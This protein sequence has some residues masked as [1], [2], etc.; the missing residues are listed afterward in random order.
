MLKYKKY[1]AAVLVFLTL[2]AGG[3]MTRHL[4]KP[5]SIDTLS[6]LDTVQEVMQSQETESLNIEESV[7]AIEK[8]PEIITYQVK[9]GDTLESI[10]RRFGVS[11]GAIAGSSGISRDSVIKEGQE[12]RFPSIDGVLYKI[13]SGETLWDISSTYGKSVAEITA[14]N[15]MDS[16]DKLKIGQEIIIPG[17]TELKAAK[18]PSNSSPASGTKNA[19]KL[20]SRG[21]S[22][23][24]GTSSNNTSTKG[25]WPLKGT[26]TSKYG[27]RWGTTHKGI[28]IAAPTGTNVN[29]F[30]GGKVSFS[31]WQGGY[32]KLVIIDHGNGLKSYYGHNSKLIVSAGQ[33]VKQGQHIAE[34]GS[35][36]D[37]TGPHCHF[38]IRKGGAAVNPMNYLK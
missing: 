34:V 11:V 13:K 25:I 8:K 2:A 38:E 6:G 18:A 3:A 1:Y 24:K 5:E 16:S 7:Q 12:L 22:S 29:A 26:L 14:V 36:G 31:G 28:D 33:Y 21:A 32:G 4:N 27:P 20:A 10:S 9:A 17:I 15:N 23:T 37:S 35:T 19:V 30:M